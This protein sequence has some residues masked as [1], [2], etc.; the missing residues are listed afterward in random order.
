MCKL[1]I[2]TDAASLKHTDGFNMEDDS[3]LSSGSEPNSLFDEMVASQDMILDEGN[4]ASPSTSYTEPAQPL[5]EPPAR[6]RVSSIPG[7]YFDPEVV[8]PDELAEDL[9]Q[10]C[11]DTYFRSEDVNQVMLFERVVPPTSISPTRSQG[12]KPVRDVS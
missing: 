1:Q 6:R 3:L 12:G 8:L 2:L 9:L 7:L 11:L 5:D 4:L 10:K